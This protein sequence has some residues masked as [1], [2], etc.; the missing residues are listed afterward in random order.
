MCMT[1]PWDP[2][3]LL[4]S[5]RISYIFTSLLS[6]SSPPFSLA[7]IQLENFNFT[8]SS[9]L[10]VII[11]SPCMHATRKT[12]KNQHTYN[13]TLLSFSSFSFSTKEREK[14]ICA[15]LPARIN[16]NIVTTRT[17]QQP[18]NYVEINEYRWVLLLSIIIHG[19]K[20]QN[21]KLSYSSFR[22]LHHRHSLNTQKCSHVDHD[23][24]LNIFQY[25]ESS[26]HCTVSSTA[27]GISK[28]YKRHVWKKG[29]HEQI[30]MSQIFHMW[31]SSRDD[32]SLSQRRRWR[33]KY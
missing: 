2:S 19:K 12:P 4:H 28:F 21:T 31:S 24:I 5:A 25:F 18:N 17:T 16:I 32:L 6:S 11:T 27:Q 22:Y 14:Y 30:I 23:E 10:I 13:F 20:T 26:S 8:K 29:R 3:S 33:W 1:R 9:S 7:I 15:N